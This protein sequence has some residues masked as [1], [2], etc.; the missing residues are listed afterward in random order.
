MTYAGSKLAMLFDPNPP[1]IAPTVKGRG[2]WILKQ[3]FATENDR[4]SLRSNPK[5]GISM[6]IYLK[7]GNSGSG[8]SLR[9]RF[10][11]PET[12]IPLSGA[13]SPT[14]VKLPPSPSPGRRHFFGFES[15]G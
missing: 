9:L 13:L 14:Q 1:L 7:S 3:I 4:G 11:V 15:T 2:Q 5:V 10:L 6:Q 8:V 12:E